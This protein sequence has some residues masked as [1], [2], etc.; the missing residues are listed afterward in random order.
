M[1]SRGAGVGERA[2]DDTTPLTMNCARLR[3]AAC[4]YTSFLC[5]AAGDA[6][7]NS[8]LCW[9]GEG[10][11][12]ISFLWWAGGGVSAISVLWWAGRGVSAISF[13]CWAGGGVS[14][15]SFLCWVSDRTLAVCTSH[16]YVGPLTENLLSVH[17]IS[18]LGP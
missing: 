14:A 6:F 18:M 9:A 4:T 13:P 8:L 15:V 16:F 5:W 2:C 12:A 17:L 3:S 1:P 10:V 11:S 7:C